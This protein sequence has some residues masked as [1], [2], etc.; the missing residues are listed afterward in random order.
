MP[1]ASTHC[2]AST[3]NSSLIG[4]AHLQPQAVAVARNALDANALGQAA[5][6]LVEFHDEAV[7]QRHRIELRLMSQPHTA[8]ERERHVGV[9]DPL[10]AQ[11]DGWQAS[12]SAR[13][14]A[15]PSSDWA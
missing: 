9:V 8:V 4:G 7:Q 2:R 10:R 12:S 1:V 15:T 5:A 3:S 13:A 14:V 6:P 11:T